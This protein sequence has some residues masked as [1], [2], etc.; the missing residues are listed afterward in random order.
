MNTLKPKRSKREPYTI[1]KKH[2]PA[3]ELQLAF[4]WLEGEITLRAVS[5][6]LGLS[7]TT[8]AYAFVASRLKYAR[9]KE[10]I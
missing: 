10:L 5:S 4:D 7:T 3:S 9:E 8:A 2:Y 6:K 1:D